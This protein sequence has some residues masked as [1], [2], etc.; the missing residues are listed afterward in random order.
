M[1]ADFPA[2]RDG[3]D[4]RKLRDGDIRMACQQACPSNGI[5]FGD[6]NDPT[7]RVSKLSKL[8]RQYKLLPE[9][10]TQPRTS[11]LAK[12]RNPNPEMQG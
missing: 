4:Q 6:L 12:I 8:D 1:H 2:Q 3:R 5:Y 9:I 10:G 7:S 11:Y